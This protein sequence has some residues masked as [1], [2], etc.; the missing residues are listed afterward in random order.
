M[1]SDSDADRWGCC[2][3]GCLDWTGATVMESWLG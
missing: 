3:A 1:Y 2:G